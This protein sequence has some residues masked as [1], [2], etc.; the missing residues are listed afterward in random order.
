MATVTL[1]IAEDLK[2]EMED[3]A[4]INWSEVAREAITERLT[5]LRLFKAIVAKSKLT[6][7]DALELGRKVNKSMHERFVREHPEAYR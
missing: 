4:I 2:K 5:Q 6:E 1:E 3:S 7:K